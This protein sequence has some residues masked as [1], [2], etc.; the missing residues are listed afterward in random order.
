M[1]CY[2]VRAAFKAKGNAAAI[3]DL[4]LWKIAGLGRETQKKFLP[5]VS[6]CSV[7]DELLNQIVSLF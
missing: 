7:N 1:V 4:I 6:K 3:Q 5:L 2:W